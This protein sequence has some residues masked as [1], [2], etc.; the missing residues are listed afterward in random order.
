[1]NEELTWAAIVKSAVA[2]GLITGDGSKAEAVKVRDMLKK[3]IERGCVEHPARGRYRF[4]F[5]PGLLDEPEA[6]DDG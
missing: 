6:N 1:M 5:V 4:K 2:L 3:Q